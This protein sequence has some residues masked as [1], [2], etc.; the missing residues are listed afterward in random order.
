MD[1]VNSIGIFFADCEGI[2]AAA[3]EAGGRTEAAAAVAQQ[4]L[5]GDVQVAD[6]HV[7]VAVAVHV[8]QCHCAGGGAAAREAGG[9]N[10]AAATVVQQQLVGVGQVDVVAAQVLVRHDYLA[11]TLESFFCPLRANPRYLGQPMSP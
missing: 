3:R 9:R 6:E 10:K 8:A 1:F 2:G 7:E 4:Q 11:K 5:V